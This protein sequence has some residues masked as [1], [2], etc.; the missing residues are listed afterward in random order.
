MHAVYSILHV[1]VC[2]NSTNKRKGFVSKQADTQNSVMYAL[3]MYETQTV[4][5]AE[6]VGPLVLTLST[7]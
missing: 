2:K 6:V 5:A 7:G 1:P 4:C 3:H